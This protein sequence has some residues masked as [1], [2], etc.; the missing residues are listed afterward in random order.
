MD[1]TIQPLAEHKQFV[2][3]LAAWHQ[4]Q[5]GALNPAKS[6]ASR[7]EE[8]AEHLQAEAPIP[9]TWCALQD[10]VLLGS[11]SLIS[12][13]LDTRPELSPW[14]ASVFVAPEH[15]GKGVGASLVQAVMDAACQTRF[16]KLY[17][18]T[19]QHEAWYYQMGWRTYEKATHNGH[20]IVIMQWESAKR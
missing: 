5:W 1:R 3:V 13:D 10:G 11:A 20:A 15:R 19:L 17:L 8:F 9:S 4:E 18:Y 12:S 2:P 7:I 6:I 16:E 14:L